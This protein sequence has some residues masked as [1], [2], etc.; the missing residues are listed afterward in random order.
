MM[1]VLL[2][3]QAVGGSDLKSETK[4]APSVTHGTTYRESSDIYNRQIFILL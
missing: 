1:W 3:G 2:L 4:E